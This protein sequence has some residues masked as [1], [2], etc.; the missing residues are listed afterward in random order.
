MQDGIAAENCFSVA[1]MMIL[2]YR[3]GRSAEGILLSRTELTLRV[4]L[5]DHDDVAEFNQF[6]GIWF[7]E[8]LEPVQIEFEW[9]THSKTN[10]RTGERNHHCSSLRRTGI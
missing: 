10:M 1:E 9:Q 5:K 8:E 7:S 4:A 6:N 3:D 2:I